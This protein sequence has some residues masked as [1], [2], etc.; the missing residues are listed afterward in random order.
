MYNARIKAKDSHDV[1]HLDTLSFS[2]DRV[3]AGRALRIIAALAGL[4][5]LVYLVILL[6]GAIVLALPGGI[7]VAGKV[8]DEARLIHYLKYGDPIDP[9]TWENTE[10]ATDMAKIR[11]SEVRNFSK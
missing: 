8:Y 5:G 3:I 2:L 11:A 10:I 7:A 6:P 9:G 4:A 1:T